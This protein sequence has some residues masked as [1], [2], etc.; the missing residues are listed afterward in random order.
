MKNSSRAALAT[1]I[2]TVLSVL[3]ATTS[4]PTPASAGAPGV[5]ARHDVASVLAGQ[6]VIVK[7]LANDKVIKRAAPR[8]GFLVAPTR[9]GPPRS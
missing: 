2:L 7:V 5:H 1:L 3:A 9:G 8:S 4:S 6:T